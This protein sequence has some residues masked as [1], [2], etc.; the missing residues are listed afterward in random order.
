LGIALILLRTSS[1]VASTWDLVRVAG[2]C[3]SAPVTVEASESVRGGVVSVTT[4]RL[5]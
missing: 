2:G 3:I 5:S 1:R 4:F